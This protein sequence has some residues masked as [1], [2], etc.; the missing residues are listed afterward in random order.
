MIEMNS[1]PAGCKVVLSVTDS[2]HYERI[3][4]RLVAL[5]VIWRPIMVQILV[6]D[7]Y[8]MM[9]VRLRDRNDK[10]SE[11]RTRFI[12]MACNEF[13]TIPLIIIS[14]C[15]TGT[16]LSYYIPA[17]LPTRRTRSWSDV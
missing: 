5:F 1:H 13:E 14:A 2:L 11:Y 10:C 8:V 4:T 15:R 17:A 16:S 3:E 9:N 7:Q 6:P 12:G